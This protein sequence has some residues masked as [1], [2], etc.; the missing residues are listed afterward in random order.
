[1]S[2]VMTWLNYSPQQS[3]ACLLCKWAK[4]EVDQASDFPD[5]IKRSRLLPPPALLFFE[6]ESYQSFSMKARVRR[7]S[8]T[9][10]SEG[11]RVEGLWD[12]ETDE[13]VPEWGPRGILEQA[14]GRNLLFLRARLHLPWTYLRACEL[15]ENACDGRAGGG[16]G[17]AGLRELF[18]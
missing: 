6:K 11:L 13:P 9:H 8:Y 2:L 5:M 14:R 7:E 16:W 1:M 15:G 3:W 4:E 17:C 18:F 10:L 12:K